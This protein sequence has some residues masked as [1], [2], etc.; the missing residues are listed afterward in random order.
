[1]PSE[2]NKKSACFHL[3][4]LLLLSVVFVLRQ[5]DPAQAV[6]KMAT[7]AFSLH[8]LSFATPLRKWVSLLAKVSVLTLTDPP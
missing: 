1:M 8:L 7:T 5:R 6:T 2:G 4:D 3:S